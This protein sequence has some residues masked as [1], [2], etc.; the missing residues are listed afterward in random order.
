MKKLILT[1]VLLLS[2]TLASAQTE[3]TRIYTKI[4]TI[5]KDK[6]PCLN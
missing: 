5:E 1:L 6:E 3:F 4:Y 2:F